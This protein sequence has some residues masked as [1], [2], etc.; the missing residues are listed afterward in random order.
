MHIGKAIPSKFLRI[1]G[2]SPERAYSYP[3]SVK[4]V[5]VFV[6]PFGILLFIACILYSALLAYVQFP[7]FAIRTAIDNFYDSIS[8]KSRYAKEES[9]T[10]KNKKCF[11]LISKIRN[12]CGMGIF[13]QEDLPTLMYC[14]SFYESLFQFCLSTMYIHFTQRSTCKQ[15][16]W[17]RDFRHHSYTHILCFN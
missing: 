6:P 8:S 4:I 10:E 17:N 14:E 11:T 12:S 7:L 15:S 16:F 9:P 2:L 3:Y 13:A 1:L 5:I